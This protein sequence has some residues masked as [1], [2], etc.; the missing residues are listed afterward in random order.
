M[1]NP[2]KHI[3]NTL[4][5]ASL[6]GF[7]NK[8]R[9]M[10][11]LNVFAL[12]IANNPKR[13]VEIHNGGKPANLPYGWYTPSTLDLDTGNN[14]LTNISRYGSSIAVPNG[15]TSTLKQS[16]FFPCNIPLDIVV[17]FD[18]QA[19]ATIFA[20]RMIVALPAKLLN[21]ELEI[22]AV[23]DKF[24]V[25]VDSGGSYSIP[26]PKIDDIDNPNGLYYEIQFNLTLKTKIGILRDVA[27]LNNNGTIT[28]G[29]S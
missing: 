16:Y 25:V 11:E 13:A 1:F 3:D 7:A 27:K 23:Q 10:F 29:E 28:I 19:A 21:F 8:I 18:E 14:N 17:R 9:E 12:N 24:T 20:Q 4:L 5:N 22:S 2:L 6:T 15:E 26:F